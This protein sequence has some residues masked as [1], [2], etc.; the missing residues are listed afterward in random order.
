MSELELATTLDPKSL[1]AAM[2]LVQTEMNLMQ[3]DKALAAIL[4][5]FRSSD[6]RFSSSLA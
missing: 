3:Y 5:P 4:T 1:Q 2:A 6:C